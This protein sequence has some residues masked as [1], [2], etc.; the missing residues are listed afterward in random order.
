MR[1][2]D[3]IVV[4][5]AYTPPGM[6][7]GAAEIDRWHKAR[8]WSGIG[9]HFVI[10]RDGRVEKGRPLE[11]VGAHVAGHNAHSIGI[12]LVGGKARE[13]DIPE[14]NYTAAQLAALRSLIEVLQAR[15]PQADILGHR[16]FPN[17]HKACPCF[18]VRSWI[19]GN[20]TDTTPEKAQPFWPGIE[21]FVPSEFDRPMNPSF[22]MLLDR[23]RE[24]AGVPFYVESTINES[25]ALLRI[26]LQEAL[27]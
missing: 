10:R 19:T 26:E 14:D 4:H 7:V 2:I 24:A 6:D 17:V 21:H 27:S 5:C 22:I 8:G 3:N 12:C 9:Y 25:A 11:K 15:F 16:D 20:K 18:D 13:Q 1:N 23:A